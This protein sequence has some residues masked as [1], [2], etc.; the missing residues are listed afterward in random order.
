PVATIQQT[1]QFIRE[2]IQH[3]YP[4]PE[5]GAIAQLVL[6]HVLRKSRMQLSLAQQEELNPEQ[7]EQVRQA[8]ERL[9]KQEPVQYVLGTAHFYGLDLQVDE[10][11]LIPRPETE[12]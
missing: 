3:A 8:V 10:R 12:E 2:S 1:A 6:E 11:V 5:A 4:E 9:K 7:E